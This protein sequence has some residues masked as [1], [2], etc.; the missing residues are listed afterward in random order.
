M[1]KYR[2]TFQDLEIALWELQGSSAASIA[3]LTNLRRRSIR[4]DHPHTRH[5][6]LDRAFWGTASGSTVWNKLSARP[7]EERVLGRLQSLKLERAGLTD[8][9]L[10]QILESNPSIKDLRLQKC[11][12]LTEETFGFLA[13]NGVAESFKV[14]E[15]TRNRSEHI[16]GRILGYIG[17]L[18]NLRVRFFHLCILY[19]HNP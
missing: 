16:D 4:L 1:D 15:F 2:H 17:E 14:F 12:A 19:I 6:D 11:L 3:R 10:R 18:P 9:Q 13:A 5:S 7:G 8:Y